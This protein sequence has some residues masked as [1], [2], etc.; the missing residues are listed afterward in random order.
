MAEPGIYLLDTNAVSHIMRNTAGAVAQRYREHLLS[1]EPP[2]MVTSVVVQC[3]LA[4]GL[5]KTPSPRLQAAYDI[6]MQQLPVLPLDEDVVG[7]YAS[8]RAALELAG[9][10]MGANDLLIAA[11]ALAVGATV[12][13]NDTDFLRVPGLAVENW[14]LAPS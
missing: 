12:V 3:E 10:P 9:T 5:A 14:L 13:T 11:H 1:T 8:L 6:Q 4:F 7:Y 2:R